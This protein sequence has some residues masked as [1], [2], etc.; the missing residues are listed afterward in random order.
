[1]RI[2]NNI[3]IS[4]TH[5]SHNINTPYSKYITH[6]ADLYRRNNNKRFYPL[7]ALF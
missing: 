2:I 3:V 5:L 1:M 4:H 7:F 6:P